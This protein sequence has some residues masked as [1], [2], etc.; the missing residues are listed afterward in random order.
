MLNVANWATRVLIVAMSGAILYTG[1]EHYKVIKDIRE[2]RLSIQ[3]NT[4]NA[5]DLTKNAQDIIKD[6]QATCD[7]IKALKDERDYNRRVANGARLQY[8]KRCENCDLEGTDMSRLPK[9]QL[10]GGDLTGAT[11]AHLAHY[12][13]CSSLPSWMTS[14]RKKDGKSNAEVIKLLTDG[15]TICE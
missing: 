3:D 8:L 7:A 10:K 15:Y 1:H 6:A 2:L 12:R 4:K 5:Q 11:N 13:K 9:G 14:E